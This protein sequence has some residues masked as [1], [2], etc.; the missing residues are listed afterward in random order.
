M[1]VFRSRLRPAVLVAV[2]L[3]A[4]MAPVALTAGALAPASSAAPASSE[5]VARG[6]SYGPWSSYFYD[7]RAR[8]AA[9]A[10]KRAR[11]HVQVE[12]NTNRSGDRQLRLSWSPAGRATRSS[13]VK[14]VAPGGRI[15]FST[16]RLPCGRTT[17]TLLGRGRASGGAWG[18]WMSISADV[19]RPC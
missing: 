18:A 3:V 7:L 9:P 8:A 10:R 2:T 16:A 4:L 14:S 6:P 1:S 12:R 5:R 11:A 13:V 17:L 19:R 15:T